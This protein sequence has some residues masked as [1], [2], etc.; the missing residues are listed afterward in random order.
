MAGNV[1]AS[2]SNAIPTGYWVDVDES[3]STTSGASG[4]SGSLSASGQGNVNYGFAQ[5]CAPSPDGGPFSV[6]HYPP[7]TCAQLGRAYA[8][9]GS[10]ETPSGFW[11]T[12]NQ[13][14]V[15]AGRPFSGSTFTW[16]VQLPQSGPWKVMAY[17]PSWTSYGFG[18][19]YVLDSADGQFQNNGFTQ[20]AYH[21]QWVTLF[22]DHNFSAGQDYTVTLKLG[23]SADGS[24][25]YQMADQMEW[26]YDGAPPP[27]PTTGTT[28][29]PTTTTTTASTVT[30]T[31]TTPHPPPPQSP[32][33]V[34]ASGSTAG[35]SGSN[36]RLR[37]RILTGVTKLKRARSVRVSIAV[38]LCGAS[39]RNAGVSDGTSLTGR[40][41]VDFAGARAAWSISL[42]ASLG[43][44]T[45]SAISHRADTYLRAPALIS[46]KR[47][48]W[49]RVRSPQF[50]KLTRLGFLAA[51][52]E[53]TNPLVGVGL[54]QDVSGSPSGR[55]RASV[56]DARSAPTPPLLATLDASSHPAGDGGCNLSGGVTLQ[57][58]LNV[59]ND[60]AAWAQA[61][62]AKKSFDTI[63]S[64]LKDTRAAVRLNPR[65]G[66]SNIAF[67]ANSGLAAGVEVATNLCP[68]AKADT[69]EDPPQSIVAQ[70]GSLA[71]IDPCLI[72]QWTLSG[73]WATGTVV[74]GTV[75]LAVLPSG[76]ATL[77]YLV[78]YPNPPD[79]V[80]VFG[81]P[82]DTTTITTQFDGITGINGQLGVT[83]L[84]PAWAYRSDHKLYWTILVNGVVSSL[85]G[86]I[87]TSDFYVIDLVGEEVVLEPEENVIDTPPYVATPEATNLESSYECD[88]NKNTGLATLSVEVPL[89]GRE[90]KFIRPLSDKQS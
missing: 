21:G 84:T 12:G 16:H 54:A 81:E 18:D 80:Q 46:G 52:A 68:Q 73:P 25:H 90:L 62:A 6:G 11:F 33:C 35:A 40:G 10:P 22:G 45:L 47:R 86:I 79:S 7:E 42:P 89:A 58:P 14:C 65:G 17:I 51:L 85:A 4:G 2:A 3:G 87:S 39:A 15:N 55:S 48:T 71:Q 60:K 31:T 34:A 43:G 70:I 20:Q 30:T 72:G 32:L 5:E 59:A 61:K 88:E 53:Y 77:T 38:R 82:P 50:R 23:D 78:S 28:T 67:S 9:T 57:S 49:V 1:W 26:V 83:V 63:R 36:H 8:P 29:T 41:V 69:G 13:N 75:T 44:G 56:H 74:N 19:Q 64:T 24:C 27:P 37:R 66:L 76:F